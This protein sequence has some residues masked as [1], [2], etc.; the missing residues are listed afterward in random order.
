MSSFQEL[1][2]RDYNATLNIKEWA[3]NPAKHAKMQQLNRF[4]YLKKLYN[5][6]PL[7]AY[8]NL[9]KIF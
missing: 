9:V 7:L 5:Q 2:D 6:N 8:K 1:L 3:L 4:E